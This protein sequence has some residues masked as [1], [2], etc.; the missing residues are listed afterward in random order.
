M[1][2]DATTKTGALA[3]FNVA[4][5]SFISGTNNP[6]N[7]TESIPTSF[8]ITPNS[9]EAYVT[10]KKD[11]LSRVSAI[12]TETFFPISEIILNTIGANPNGIAIAQ[13]EFPLFVV[14]YVSFDNSA[15][16]TSLKN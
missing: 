9:K 13:L 10:L 15:F 3:K 14:G 6:Y 8:I 1:T 16:L 7:F 5:L 11:T 2:S 12:D 4:P